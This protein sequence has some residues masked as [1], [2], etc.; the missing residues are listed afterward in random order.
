MG[1]KCHD[2][3]QRYIENMQYWLSGIHLWRLRLLWFDL[4]SLIYSVWSTQF[5]SVM[6]WQSRSNAKERRNCQREPH[7]M[8]LE[9]FVFVHKLYNRSHVFCIIGELLPG[10]AGLC[11]KFVDPYRGPHTMVT[12]SQSILVG[13]HWNLCTELNNWEANSSNEHKAV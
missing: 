12:G 11:I 10:A 6:A 2:L 3:Q 4:L 8:F 7:H 5:V 9:S 13:G 1:H